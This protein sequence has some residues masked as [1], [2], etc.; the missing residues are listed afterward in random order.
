MS[1]SLGA[2]PSSSFC[3][4]DGPLIA[5]PPPRPQLPSVS[6]LSALAPRRCKNPA[7]YL[8]TLAG[9]ILP[10]LP[11]ISLEPCS[12]THTHNTHSKR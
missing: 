6:L 11:E 12:R 8:A 2:L 3:S 4:F 10:A 5:P 9:L 1:L 7:W